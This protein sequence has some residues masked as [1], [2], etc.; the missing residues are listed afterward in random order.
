[1]NQVQNFT[2]GL[3]KDNPVLRL[4]LGFCPVLAVT[5]SAMN[6]LGMGAATTFVLVCS[7]IVVAAI[8]GIV[9][10]QMRIPVYV[11]VIASFVTLVDLLLQGFAYP[12]SKSLG[13]FIPL[14]VVNCV[15]LGRAESF[16]S[17]NSI[18]SS[19]IDGLGMGLGFTAALVV[20]GS[21]RE[22][23]G[24]GRIFGAALV[25]VDTPKILIFVLPPG[26]FITLGLL[27]WVM[28]ELDARRAR[29]GSSNH[30]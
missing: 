22:I 8:K 6:A 26:A 10:S 17:K 18:G 2:K 11:V 13:L 9:P 4:L 24:D 20:L 29:S 12:L 3:W 23:L 21:I 30:G 14:I 28:N 19:F 15:I 16:A 25:S 1:M 7:N 5:T 27:L